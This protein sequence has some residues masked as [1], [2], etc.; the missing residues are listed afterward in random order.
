MDDQLQQSKQAAAEQQLIDQQ[1]QE[2]ARN[3]SSY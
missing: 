3:P 1:R 2:L